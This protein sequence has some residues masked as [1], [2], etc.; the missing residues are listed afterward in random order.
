V[1][2]AID[3]FLSNFETKLL[4]RSQAAEKAAVLERCAQAGDVIGRLERLLGLSGDGASSL[5]SLSEAVCRRCSSNAHATQSA[6]D[7]STLLERVASGVNPLQL[8]L[9]GAQ[10]LALMRDFQR[11]MRVAEGVLAEGLAQVFRGALQTRNEL[12]ALSCLR[13]CAPYR[14]TLLQLTPL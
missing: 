11:R 5:L 14:V 4:H 3:T 7:A 13:T 6:A 8:H 12:V 1:R 10:D 2:S 9:S